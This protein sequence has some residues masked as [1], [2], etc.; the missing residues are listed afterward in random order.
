[1]GPETEQ[2]AWK[3]KRKYHYFSKFFFEVYWRKIEL[4]NELTT[5][6]RIFFSGLSF[7]PV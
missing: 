3:E 1:M 6:T 7:T 5:G 4:F 2:P